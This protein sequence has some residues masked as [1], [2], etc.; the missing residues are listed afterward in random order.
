VN[1]VE[2]HR[3]EREELVATLR[4]FGPEAPTLCDDWSAAIL[5]SH[6]VA[7]EQAGG[8]P[9]ALV[10]TL[11]GVLGP[12]LAAAGI[13]R[14][15]PLMLR[16]ME[17]VERQGWDR[18]LARLEAGPPSLFRLRRLG[19]IR[20]LEDWI[21]HEDVRRANGLGPRPPDPVRD[22]ALVTGIEAV[23]HIPEFANLRQGIAVRLPDGRSWTASGDPTV[24]LEGSPG[25]ILLALAG[26][27]H[28][29]RVAV[30]G[31]AALLG[32]ESL[33]F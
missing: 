10:W 9:W 1:V 31:D 7:A 8:V 20:L 33:R 17:G 23:S 24:S 3:R 19:Q 13:R 28:V 25:E 12:R 27:A 32:A 6:L 2:A 18:I 21:H 5:A 26:R 16:A 4:H 22:E 11:R 14:L 29:A 15:R 30:E